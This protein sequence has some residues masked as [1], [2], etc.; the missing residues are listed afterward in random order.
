MMKPVVK[1]IIKA[2]KQAGYHKQIISTDNLANGIYFV[3][4]EQNQQSI[5]KKLLIIN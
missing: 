3:V 4:L 2:K 1:T 5:S